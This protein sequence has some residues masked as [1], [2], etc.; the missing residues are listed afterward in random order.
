[1]TEPQPPAEPT[2]V[3]PP[4]AETPAAPPPEAPAAPAAETPAPPETDEVTEPVA[5]DADAVAELMPAEAA[6]A[7]AADE[8]AAP[9]PAPAADAD[10]TQPTMPPASPPPAA[11][12]PVAPAAAVPVVTT[13]PP[14]PVV[15]APVAAVPVAVAAPPKKR[16]ATSTISKIVAFL[17]GI[18]QALLVLRIV[19]LL[20]VA[21]QDNAI[22][23]WVLSVTDPFVEPFRGVFN[24]DE[25]EGQRGAVLDVAAVVA[26]IAWSLIETLILS[27]LRLIGRRD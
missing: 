10:P 19:L 15:A 11:P 2:P 9:P 25:I 26:I 12:P 5:L 1:M 22:V 8:P 17:F 18:L 4:E 13:T 14:A 3:T 7:A 16:S 24:L 6:A 20:L 21:N 23:S 27:V